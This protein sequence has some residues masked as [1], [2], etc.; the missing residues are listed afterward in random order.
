MST[1][2]KNLEELVWD[3][4]ER[5]PW[6][7]RGPYRRRMRRDRSREIILQE[8]RMKLADCD[9]C[10]EMG[11]QQLMRSS[12]VTNT[13]RFEVD[14]DN[15]EQFFQLILEYLP[16]I[17]EMILSFFDDSSRRAVR[18]ASV[19]LVLLGLAQTS[20]VT[21]QELN[22]LTK[23]EI[24]ADRLTAVEAAAQVE[25]VT[26]S[27]DPETGAN[28]AT[29]VAPVSD[30]AT[31]HPRSEPGWAPALTA[32]TVRSGACGSTAVSRKR[33][34]TRGQMVVRADRSSRFIDRPRGPIRRLIRRVRQ[35]RVARIEARNSSCR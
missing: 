35:R 31:L 29:Y 15:L 1:I 13:T 20:R 2:Q 27:L 12:A 9:R 23:A 11:Y 5:A 21:A 32:I 22:P 30:S 14:L 7:R 16:Q 3:A 4:I 17:M 6:W 33:A 10:A 26:P 18:A 24:E 28:R 19:V 8:L 34:H 25:A